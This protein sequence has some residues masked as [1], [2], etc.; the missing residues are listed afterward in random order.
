MTLK[1]AHTADL[2]LDAD[3]V[4]SYNPETGIH[5]AWESAT[6]VWLGICGAVA[7]D[8]D[9]PVLVVPGDLF[10][11]GRPSAEAQERVAEGFR[12]VSAAGKS[13]VLS[14]GNHELIRLRQG[15]R[16]AL[17]R[18]ADIEGVYYFDEPTLWRDP[19]SGLQV[20]VLPWT[21]KGAVTSEI[22]QA[23]IDDPAQLDVLV[24]DYISAQIRMMAEKVDP[25]SPAVLSGHLTVS[26]SALSTGG[27]G[28]EIELHHIMAEPV[29]PI[30][31]LESDPWSYVALGHIHVRQS[32]GDTGR[33]WYPGSPERL[34]FSEADASKSFNMV[35]VSTDPSATSI[36]HVPTSARRLVILDGAEYNVDESSLQGAL[37]RVQLAKGEVDLDRG[38]AEMVNDCGGKV[39]SVR[40]FKD[41]TVSDV[42]DIL[43]C[44]SDDGLPEDL[45]W[46]EYADIW[47]NQQ[48]V[49]GDLGVEVKELM[50]ELMDSVEC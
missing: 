41:K 26:A 42:S 18:Y 17:A 30:S 15:H 11:D 45:S 21:T 3:H 48:G 5:S 28:S 24:A 35:S 32:V 22:D 38:F 23:G 25:S 29:V 8:P 39:V 50:S 49:S 9:C 7:D 12:L 31:A 33:V 20:G 6:D 34:S 47:L 44:M 19:K 36:E 37:V 4:G 16:T 10:K 13:V 27:R 2:H 1:V 46:G 43:A 14:P 40:Q